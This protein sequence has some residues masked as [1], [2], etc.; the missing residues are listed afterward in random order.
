MLVRPT[1]ADRPNFGFNKNN[2][3]CAVKHVTKVSV[4]G[5]LQLGVSAGLGR[6]G[7]G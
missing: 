7:L 4:N 3:A 5:V 1:I 2:H 6:L